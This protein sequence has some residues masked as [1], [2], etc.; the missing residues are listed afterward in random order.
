MAIPI[1]DALLNTA[2]TVL[3]K[4]IPDVNE[5]A[6]LA[7]EL[8][9]MGE[10]NTHALLQGQ[11]EISKIE[12]ASEKWWKAGPRP[13]ILWIGG[14]ARANNFLIAPYIEFFTGSSLSLDT[15]ALFPLITALLGIGGMRSYDKRRVKP[16]G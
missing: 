8:A 2:N 3:D 7:Q 5:R 12:A 6:K 10:R 4:V 13:F 1:F 11:L 16:D 14:L 9:T 15:E